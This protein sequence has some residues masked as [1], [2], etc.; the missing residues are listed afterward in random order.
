[1]MLKLYNTLTRKKQPFKSIKAGKV[2]MYTCGPTVY[3][4]Q[5]IGN[6]RSYIFSDVLK[7]VLKYGGYKVDHVINVTDVGHLTSDADSGEDKLEKAAASEGRSAKDI[8]DYYFK[9]FREDFEKL[10]IIEP[11]IW[12][13]ATEH[14]REQITLITKL[15]EKGYTYETSDGIYFDTSKYKDYGKLSRKDIAGLEAGKRS[16][17]REKK[18]A[19]DFALWK[20]SEEPGKRQ[21]E[22]DSPWGVGFPGWHIECSAMSMNYLGETFDIHTGGEDHIGVHHENEIAQSECATGKT[23]VNY[24]MH[25]AFLILKG[26]KMS[27][28]SGDILTIAQ[29]EEKGFDPMAYRYFIYSAHYRK[30]L[31][32]SLEG[33][34]SAQNAYKKAKNVVASLEDDGKENKK[35]L[36]DFEKA[37]ND[38]LDMPGAIAVLWGLLRDDKA[39][40]KVGAIKKMEEVLGL[41]LFEKAVFRVPAEIREIAEERTKARAD[42]DWKKSDKLRDKLEKE[43]WK[44]KDSGD[45]FELEKL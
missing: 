26:G 45:D 35:Y 15:E 36:K 3:W 21:Q 13:K 8:A 33:L 31:T 14:I 24:W 9:V 40:G 34:K 43:G 28:S 12:S 32:W 42:K 18:N 41:R 23:F 10:N 4:Y 30:P 19:T 25:G 38:D 20:F 16:E 17:M 27:K 2:G 11:S 6:L 44:I 22:W 29:L 37:I 5:H 7:R 1:M 39:E